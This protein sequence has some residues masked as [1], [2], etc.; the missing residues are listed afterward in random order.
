MGIWGRPGECYI[1]LSS[2][3]ELKLSLPQ[4][5]EVTTQGVGVTDELQ[6]WKCLCHSAN[7]KPLPIYKHNLNFIKLEIKDGG[8][9]CLFSAGRITIISD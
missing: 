5:M 1:S 2:E 8:N 4:L 3:A 7:Q 6:W 9:R